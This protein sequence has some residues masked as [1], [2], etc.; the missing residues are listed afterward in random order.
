MLQPWEA[1]CSREWSQDKETLRRES[2]VLVAEVLGSCFKFLFLFPNFSSHKSLWDNI[3]FEIC[4]CNVKRTDSYCVSKIRGSSAHATIPVRKPPLLSIAW[5]IISKS[6][7][8]CDSALIYLSSL[9]SF[10]LVKL[11]FSLFLQN[12]YDV[13]L[14]TLSHEN[15]FLPPDTPVS[16]FWNCIHF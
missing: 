6:F 3:Y 10:N 1:S 7:W 15:Y 13:F 16:T 11:N 5:K 12:T 2:F 4:F 8:L 14:F 9:I